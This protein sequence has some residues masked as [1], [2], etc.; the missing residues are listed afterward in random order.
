MSS[1]VLEAA[2]SKRNYRSSDVIMGVH[3]SSFIPK[4]KYLAHA[5]TIGNQRWTLRSVPIIDS[6]G[7]P[8][9]CDLGH[10]GDCFRVSLIE[11][12]GLLGSISRLSEN[13]YSSLKFS[14]IVLYTNA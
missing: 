11:A 14:N 7:V 2:L 13:F 5:T 4:V 10:A 9:T 8:G 6:R 3:P 1:R 12:L